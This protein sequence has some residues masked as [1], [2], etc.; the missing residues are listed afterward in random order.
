MRSFLCEHFVKRNLFTSNTTSIQSVPICPWYRIRTSP[1]APPPAWHHQN[2]Q[3]GRNKIIFHVCH[4]SWLRFHVC[5]DDIELLLWGLH[6]SASLHQETPLHCSFFR[7]HQ[8]GQGKRLISFWDGLSP[9]LAA[10]KSAVSTWKHQ[11]NSAT[12][13]FTTVAC[14]SWSR[15]SL[16]SPALRK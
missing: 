10:I 6:I 8:R 14:K 1:L 7:L 15:R 2:L 12:S 11:T 9:E 4:D 3:P 13:L 5:H 16:A